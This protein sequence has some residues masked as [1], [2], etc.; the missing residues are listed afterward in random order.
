MRPKLPTHRATP[1]RL[2]LS[3]SILA[4][5]VALS[6]GCGSSSHAQSS[7]PKATTLA[8]AQR[9]HGTLHVVMRA[10]WFYPDAP[11]ASVG[12]RVV[13]KNIDTSPHNV[14]YVSG[15][16]FTS[17]RRVMAPGATF[18]LQLTRAGTIH[19]YCSIHPWMKATIVVA[20]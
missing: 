9:S 18:S 6:T 5:L 13:W 14:T 8:S 3:L 11:H 10:L 7:T 15:P 4:L 16:R 17:S 1:G 20:Q 2:P 19:Y 12:Q